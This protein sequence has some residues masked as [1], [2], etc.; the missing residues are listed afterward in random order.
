MIINI[1][2]TNGSGKSTVVR[3]I[4]DRA[5]RCLP[6]HGVLGLRRPEA[7]KLEFKDRTP[8]YVLGPYDVPTGGCDAVHP[9]SLILDLVHK[10]AP[11]GHVLFEGSLVS[12]HYGKMGALLESFG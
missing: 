12:D 8:V 7:Y 11:Q 9:F 6:I 10:Y 4:M 1:R 3:Q 2:G 5:D